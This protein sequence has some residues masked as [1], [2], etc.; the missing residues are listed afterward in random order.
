M[1]K[2]V[3]QLITQKAL[4][5]GFNNIKFIEAKPLLDSEEHFLEWRKKGYAADMDYLLKDDPIHAR[6]EYLLENA[7][8][9]IMM[10]AN[11]Y[12]PCPPRPSLEHGRIAS[13]AVGLDYHKVLKQ[14]IKL[15]MEDAE[16]KEVLKH[17]KFFTDAVPLLEKSFAKRAG[18]GFQGRNSLLISRETGSFNF[19]VEIITDLVIEP[20]LREDSVVIAR[21][22]KHDVAIP[23]TEAGRLLRSARNDSR[24]PH[25]DDIS[26]GNCT[27]CMDICPTNALPNEY[28]LDA[29]KCI[30]YH[31][32]ENRNEIPEELA[33]NFGE[34][35]FGCDL[36]QTICPYNRKVIPSEASESRTGLPRHSVP[37]YDN[38]FP[39]FSPEAGFG[40]WLY[41][42]E[43][44]ELQPG[45]HKNKSELISRLETHKFIDPSALSQ[46]KTYLEKQN[47]LTEEVYDRIF[48]IKFARTPL[49]RPKRKGLIRN[50]E[51]VLRNSSTNL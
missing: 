34:W 33:K 24:S 50:A 4:A 14:K 19:I 44:I 6:P 40:H 13:Y 23:S 10:T 37:R 27:R 9:L 41:L 22:V 12:S 32:I 7:K 49:L 2:E 30:S 38:S 28:Q 47:E 39:E 17:A 48:Q 26:C 18:L 8:T 35:I 36:C 25:N 3:S 42:P 43:I 45:K 1:S 46:I 16:I 5:I 21:S 11:Y 29:R 15:L 31:T 20:S 51:I